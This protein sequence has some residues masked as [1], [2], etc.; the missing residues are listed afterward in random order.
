VAKKKHKHFVNS[1]E[2]LCRG[3]V[4]LMN[5]THPTLGSTASACFVKD[6]LQLVAVVVSCKVNQFKEIAKVTVAAVERINE[7]CNKFSILQAEKVE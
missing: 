1:N 5:S 4:G 3:F 2:L 6:E 7:L